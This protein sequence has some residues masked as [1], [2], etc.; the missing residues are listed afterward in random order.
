MCES[1][2]ESRDHILGDC[3]YSKEVWGRVLQFLNVTPVFN[4]WEELIP[5]F[6][7]MPQA[8]LKTKLI[9]AA[10]TRVLNGLWRARNIKIFREESTPPAAIVQETIYYLKMKIGALKKESFPMED[11]NWLK[12]M[13]FMD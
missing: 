2:D 7:G 3:S 9:A 11:V 12:S 8:R 6:I 10:A 13:R 1:I 4:C 5:L